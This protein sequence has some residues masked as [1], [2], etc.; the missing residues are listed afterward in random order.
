VP[1]SNNRLAR[2]PAIATERT[3]AMQ[4]VKQPSLTVEYLSQPTL[5]SRMARNNTPVYVGLGLLLLGLAAMAAP[6]LFGS[7]AVRTP[8]FDM[9]APMP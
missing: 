3:K 4:Q 6:V 9:S 2:S 5:L 8:G 1:G 7:D